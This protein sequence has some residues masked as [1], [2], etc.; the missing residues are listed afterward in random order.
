MTRASVTAVVL[1]A[2]LGTG[3]VDAA[4]LRTG[5]AS[6]G[7][8]GVQLVD[9][10]RVAWLDGRCTLDCEFETSFEGRLSVLSALPNGKRRTAVFKRRFGPLA[11][12]DGRQPAMGLTSSASLGAGQPA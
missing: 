11:V 9:G 1:L 5:P 4:P 2:V 6:E 10:D 12:D 3:V 8:V 7:L